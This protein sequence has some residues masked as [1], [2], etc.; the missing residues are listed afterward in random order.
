VSAKR[1]RGL[2]LSSLL[3]PKA[4]DDA[5]TK[6]DSTALISYLREYE[7]VSRDLADLLADIL[8]GKIRVRQRKAAKIIAL[9][10]EVVPL[11]EWYLAVLLGT[12]SGER[13]FLEEAYSACADRLEELGF[14]GDLADSPV[15][16]A[17]I[18]HWV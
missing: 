11:Y 12:L 13:E 6:G 18:S 8:E 9:R 4:I 16:P 14:L 2:D 10:R 1:L 15:A 7:C 5:R 3:L 17:W